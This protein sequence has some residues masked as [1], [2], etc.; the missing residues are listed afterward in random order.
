MFKYIHL[1]V[2]IATLTVFGKVLLCDSAPAD[3]ENYEQDVDIFLSNIEGET[4]DFFEAESEN[5]WFFNPCTSFYKP[6]CSAVCVRP[7]KSHN[8]FRKIIDDFFHRPQ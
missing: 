2:L 1:F 6:A 8:F 4:L 5:R 3:D 7:T